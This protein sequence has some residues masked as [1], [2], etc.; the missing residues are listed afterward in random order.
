[1]VEPHCSKFRMI[2]AIFLVIRYL[3][4]LRWTHKHTRTKMSQLMRLWYLSYRRPVKSQA[5]SP[6]PSLYAHMKYGSRR[7]VQRKSSPTG[8][9]RMHVWKMSLRRTESTIISWHGSNCFSL[10]FLSVPLPH[11]EVD[12]KGNSCTYCNK[13]LPHTRHLRI[14]ERIHTGEKPFICEICGKTFTQK[15]HLTAHQRIHSGDKPYSCVTCGKSFVEKKSLTQHVRIHSGEKPYSCL[16]CGKLFTVKGN[17]VVHKRLHSG[18]KPYSCEICGKSFAQIGSVISHKRTH[19]GH[20]PYS[21]KTC[22]KAFGDRKTLCRHQAVHTW[23]KNY[24]L[25]F[26]SMSGGK[27]FVQTPDIPYWKEGLY[28]WYLC[29]SFCGQK[30]FVHTHDKACRKENLSCETCVK[31]F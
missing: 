19:T 22:G 18:E 23:E 9:L 13:V 7:R 6:E 25:F 5:S 17:L 21:C 26:I 27:Q 29:K 20:K 11:P 12:S 4:I 10:S 3:G 2:T 16:V 8:W 30:K 31:L 28:L 15:G 1:M 24:V 14:H